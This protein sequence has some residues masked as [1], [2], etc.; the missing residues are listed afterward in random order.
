M[1]DGTHEVDEVDVVINPLDASVLC[2]SPTK[3]QVAAAL[4]QLSSDMFNVGV[5]M[6]YLGGFNEG[7]KQKSFELIGAS[8]IA[9]SWFDEI[10]GSE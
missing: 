1:T 9:K 7:W 4:G 8:R 5:A 6:E 2:S 3:D 10:E